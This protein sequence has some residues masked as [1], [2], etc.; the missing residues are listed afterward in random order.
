MANTNDNNG[1]SLGKYGAAYLDTTDLFEPPTGMV[2]TAIQFLAQNTLNTLT[3][4]DTDAGARR[5][6]NTANAAHAANESL[7]GNN[8]Q[9]LDNT[10]IFPAGTTI[11]GRWNS[12]KLQTADGDGGVI[13]YLAPI[14]S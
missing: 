9:Q 12:V 10:C 8:G 14:G 2:I 4:V 1:A 11:Y 6:F 5:F 13:I 3:A 7:E